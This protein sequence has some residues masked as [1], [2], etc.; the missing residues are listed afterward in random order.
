MSQRVPTA[1]VGQMLVFE[2][3]FS[4]VWAH[5]YEWKLP[6]VSLVI[7]M[8][9]LVGGVVYA[10]KLFSALEGKDKNETIQEL[11]TEI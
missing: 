10:L 8:I 1:L 3:I 4:V 9:C 11:P 7:G 6:P 2:T 5:V